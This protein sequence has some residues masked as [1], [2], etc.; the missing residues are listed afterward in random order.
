[1]PVG[2]ARSLLGGSSSSSR[3]AS[4]ATI[5]NESGTFTYSLTAAT[6]GSLGN[7]FEWPTGGTQRGGFYIQTPQKVGAN[8]G[9]AT[10]EFYIN[11]RTSYGSDQTYFEVDNTY[12][13]AH[14]NSVSQFRNNGSGNSVHFSGLNIPRD[15]YY[16]LNNWSHFAITNVGNT[17]DWTWFAN[18]TNVGTVNISATD[19][20]DLFAFG[21]GTNGTSM[22]MR[23]DEIRISNIRRY[24]SSFTPQTTM[25]VNDANTVALFGCDTTDNLDNNT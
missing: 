13:R 24:T 5:W 20:L 2:F 12:V 1:M 23:I 3:T 22:T 15:T 4:T 16:P 17:N 14:G 10:V 6:V 8:A 21:K 25:F 19:G 11:I 9:P 18:G 7:A